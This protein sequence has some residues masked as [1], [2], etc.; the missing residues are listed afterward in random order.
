MAKKLCKL[1]KKLELKE[2]AAAARSGDF[3]CSKCGRTASDKK[4]LC[5]PVGVEEL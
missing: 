4:S 2:I 1:A 5:R 3:I